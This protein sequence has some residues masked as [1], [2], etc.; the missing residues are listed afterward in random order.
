M[1]SRIIL[2][3]GVTEVALIPESE[4]ER[5]A[6]HQLQVQKVSSAR[7]RNIEEAPTHT[8]IESF[9]DHHFREHLNGYPSN[10]PSKE[11]HQA[12]V[13]ML[14][15]PLPEDAKVEGPMPGFAGVASAMQ[16]P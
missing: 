5:A 8:I 15:E 3:D 16:S 10:F 11:K 14:E 9:A 4:W 1:K 13:V 6:L 2:K 12:M 7:W